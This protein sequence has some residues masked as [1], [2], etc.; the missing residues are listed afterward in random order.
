MAPDDDNDTGT[1]GGMETKPE[2]KAYER[3]LKEQREAARREEALK[4]AQ[5][6]REEAER[7]QR[8]K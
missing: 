5:R 4:E 3:I 2:M 7:R 6:R 1:D 8:E